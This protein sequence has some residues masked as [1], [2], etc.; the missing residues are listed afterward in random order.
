MAKKNE[1]EAKV[2][3]QEAQAAETSGN[4][5][6]QGLFSHVPEDFDKKD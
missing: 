3:E 6:G 4:N 5:Q 2:Q 1:E